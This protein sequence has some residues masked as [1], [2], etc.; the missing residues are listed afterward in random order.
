M[1]VILSY[2]SIFYSDRKSAIKCRFYSPEKAKCVSHKDITVSVNLKT[3]TVLLA[4]ALLFY[5]IKYFLSA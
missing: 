3:N 5:G 4:C 1:Q 2:L